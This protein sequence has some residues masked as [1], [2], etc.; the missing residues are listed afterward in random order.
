MNLA[1]HKYMNMIDCDIDVI[2]VCSAHRKL[3]CVLKSSFLRIT[4]HFSVM[5]LHMDPAAAACEKLSLMLR[6]QTGKTKISRHHPVSQ[7]RHRFQ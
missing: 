1:S 5:L 2:K 3:L 6:L 4:P 7:L